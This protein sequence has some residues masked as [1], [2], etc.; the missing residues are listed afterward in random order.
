MTTKIETS[1]IDPS[2]IDPC[3]LVLF[4]AS[5]NLSRVKLVPGLYRLESLGR[6]PEKMKILS[7]GRQLVEQDAWRAEI[8]KMLEEKFYNGLDEA[9]F[10]R[11]IERNHYQA[12]PPTDPDA[13]KKLSATLSDEKIF[14]QN[15]AYFLSVRPVDFAPVVEQLAGVGLVDESKY[16]RQIHGS[17]RKEIR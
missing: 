7:V 4:G 13:F 12:N 6:L 1:N 9:V 2:N 8:R 16:W 14:P 17:H 10:K 3:T 11:F 15:L 5:G